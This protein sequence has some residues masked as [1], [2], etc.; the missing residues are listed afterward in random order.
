M[1]SS[2]IAV[3]A[4]S[5]VFVRCIQFILFID[6]IIKQLKEPNKNTCNFR[7]HLVLID[8]RIRE[9]SSQTQ[10]FEYL[11]VKHVEFKLKLIERDRNIVQRMI[12]MEERMKELINASEKNTY[13]TREP[14]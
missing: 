11:Y 10:I 7:D 5:A 8:K 3:E 4:I 6:N 2:C 13:I 1:N 9:Q 12:I 14:S